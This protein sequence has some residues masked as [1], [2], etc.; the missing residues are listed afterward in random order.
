[1]SDNNYKRRLQSRN[2][3]SSINSVFETSNCKR[4][5]KLLQSRRKEDA[6]H[7]LSQFNEVENPNF[8][9]R[10][11]ATEAVVSSTSISYLVPAQVQA[12]CRK[13]ICVRNIKPDDP[14]N[15]EFIGVS[16]DVKHTRLRRLFKVQTTTK[17]KECKHWTAYRLRVRPPVFTLEKREDSIVDERGQEYKA[18]DIYVISDQNLIFEA[19]KIIRIVG[20]PLPDPRSQQITVLVSDVSFPE[21]AKNFD[22]HALLRLKDWLAAK[23]VKDRVEWLLS[24]FENHSN[25]VGRRNLAF[26]GFLTFFSPLWVNLDGETQRGWL[27]TITLGDTTTGKS[28]TIRKLISLLQAGMLITAETA[29]GVGLTGTAT[30]VERV[31]WF[32]EWGFLVLNDRRLLAV[33][34][35]Q[36]LSANQWASLAESERSGVVTIAKAAKGS[37]YARTRQL[38]LANP[39]NPESNKYSTRALAEFLYPVQALPTILDPTSIARLDL[40]TFADQ[41]DVAPLDIN[42][43]RNNNP[44]ED[45]EM[46]KLLPE[47]L[48]WCWS[49]VAKVRYDKEAKKELLE[50]AT[51]LYTKFFTPSIPLVSIDMKWKLTRLTSALAFLTL[52]TKDLKTV[53]VTKDHVHIIADFLEKEYAKAGL[54]TL[55]QS[56]KYEVLSV[57]DIEEMKNDIFVCTKLPL[58]TIDAIL[59]FI[60]TQGRVTKDQLKERFSLADN[61]QLRPLMA[62]LQ[63]E[64]LVKVGHGLYP[65]PK[66]IQAFKLTTNNTINNAAN[67][68]QPRPSSIPPTHPSPSDHDNHANSDSTQP[69]PNV[70]VSEQA[71]KYAKIAALIQK[72]IEDYLKHFEE[73]LPDEDPMKAL[74]AVNCQVVNGI[75][76]FKGC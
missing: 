2:R 59:C 14:A 29:S 71:K 1:M 19:G 33:D 37:A 48:K 28:A 45:Q 50:Q 26:A 25:I 18:L 57:E 6:P 41:R 65:T 56:Q 49:K 55:A 27:D 13:K 31:G 38:K 61:N 64:G 47:A 12:T 39:V 69:A 53:T 44:S 11:V 46:L 63:N 22:E 40:A 24:T 10:L 68:A 5:H 36:K 67:E 21:N 73:N 51:A 62:A 8:S 43:P 30:Q 17:I 58:E 23:P 52:S 76:T 9:G 35:V 42:K 3:R 72:P 54:N 7:T 16:N 34:G 20:T 75:V 74:E 60:A 32:V 4:S 15:L 70:R 66:L